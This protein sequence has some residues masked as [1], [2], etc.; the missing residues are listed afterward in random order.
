MLFFFIKFKLKWFFA[1]NL[2]IRVRFMNNF[3]V[4]RIKDLGFPLGINIQS[5]DY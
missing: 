3:L 5:Q 2:I 4:F 1:L